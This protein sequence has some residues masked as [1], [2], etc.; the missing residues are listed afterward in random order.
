MAA[1]TVS[2]HLTYGTPVSQ[3]VIAAWT[4]IGQHNPVVVSQKP[5]GSAGRTL[6]QGH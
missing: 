2:Q 6:V 4:T 5:D 1:L 3:H